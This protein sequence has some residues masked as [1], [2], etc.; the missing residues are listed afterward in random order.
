MET[1]ARRLL[2]IVCVTSLL[3]NVMLCT[4]TA[5]EEAAVDE[6]MEELVDCLGMPGASI[7]LV[8]VSARV[9]KCSGTFNR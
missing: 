9:Y 6:F 1:V 8:R 2:T 3:I 5:E 7:S 4:L